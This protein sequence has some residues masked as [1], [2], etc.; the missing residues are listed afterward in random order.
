MISRLLGSLTLV[1]SLLTGC[2]GAPE[3]LKEIVGVPRAPAEPRPAGERRWVLVQNPRFG[4]TMAEPEYI[5]VED[6]RI[7]GG[8]TT[9]LFGRS[10]VIAPPHIVPRYGPPPGDGPISPLQAG[11]AVASRAPTLPAAGPRGLLRPDPPPSGEAGRESL[12]TREATAREPVVRDP[13]LRGY[14]VH[15]Q[16][17]LI[18]VDLTSADG[19]R[20]GSVLSVRRGRTPLTHPVT[21]E[22]LGELE[23]EEVATARVVELRERFSVAE[24]QEIR[25]GV[26]LRVKDRVVVS[27]P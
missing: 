24:I 6:D 16:A 20:K 17:G 2:A 14:V 22:P 13:M 25:P 3:V 27:Q 11:P 18:V 7:P 1:A 15:V 4:A 8:L 12:A 9:A 5:W 26:E 19:I 21:R 10:A 23:E